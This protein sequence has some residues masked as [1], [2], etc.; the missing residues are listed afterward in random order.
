[1][2]TP[3]TFGRKAP[4]PRVVSAPPRIQAAAA[5]L[6]A[7]PKATAPPLAPKRSDDVDAELAAWN[8]G[9]KARKR[10]FREPWRTVSIVTSLGFFVSAGL[11]PGSV[12][13]VTDYVCIGL[14][15]ASILAGYRKPSVARNADV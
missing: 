12:A 15:A 6:F 5:P 10:S 3:K 14:S 1:M 2:Q 11:L 9:R 4:P 13:H 8:A 7:P